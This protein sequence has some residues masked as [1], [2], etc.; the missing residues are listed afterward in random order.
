MQYTKYQSTLVRPIGKKNRETLIY[1]RIETGLLYYN[2]AI[3]STINYIMYIR[4][5]NIPIVRG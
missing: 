3:I 1:M 2:V 4:I 5:G